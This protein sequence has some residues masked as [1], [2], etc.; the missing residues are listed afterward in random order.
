MKTCSWQEPDDYCFNPVEGRT[1]YCA[2]HNRLIR[3]I[4]EDEKKAL[5][6]REK[7]L[8]KVKLQQSQPKTA[9]KK[10]SEKRKELNKEYFKLV[11]QFKKDNPLCK[12]KVNEY[13]TGK[14]DDPHHRR[15]RGEYLLQVA[16]WLPCC[17]SCHSYIENHPEEAKE[18]GWSES[19]LAKFAE[20]HKI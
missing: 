16:T 6:K 3:K 11:D 9:I 20:P 13:C 5:A 10:V 4:E 18:K 8:L 19:R 12:A 2:R 7:Q 15:G 14:T 17:R 1:E